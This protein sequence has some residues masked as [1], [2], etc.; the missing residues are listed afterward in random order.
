M[1]A[2]SKQSLDSA[3]I[4]E[5]AAELQELMD[6][7]T[8]GDDPTESLAAFKNRGFDPEKSRLTPATSQLDILNTVLQA[9]GAVEST[10][11]EAGV[12]VA[13]MRLLLPNHI[14]RLAGLVASA[15]FTQQLYS[16]LPTTN[17]FQQPGDISALMSRF[18]NA[19]RSEL[20]MDE[21]VP[22]EVRLENLEAMVGDAID[23]RKVPN[24]S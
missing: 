15:R 17:K 2:V 1:Q 21:F 24:N 14:V 6:R 19:V 16:A 11:S 10:L 20:G 22:L 18:V 4:K 5:T 7:L 8:N 12:I 9:I 23:P 13:E 3:K